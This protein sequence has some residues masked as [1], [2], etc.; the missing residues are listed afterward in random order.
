MIG[1]DTTFVIQAEV[2]RHP[3]HEAARALLDK[4]LEDGETLA[5]AP[6]VLAEFIHIVTDDRRFDAPLSVAA[7]R[8]RAEQWWN[9]EEVVH[10]VPN[11][12]TV[13][14][15]LAWLHRHG[16]GRKRLLDTMLAAT[17]ATNEIESVVTSNVRDFRIFGRFRLLEVG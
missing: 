8:R 16:L 12:H 3:G 15:F 2:V 7:A 17:Y 6:Q 5:L 9:A 1:V 10:A 13:P 4:M 11:E 14:L